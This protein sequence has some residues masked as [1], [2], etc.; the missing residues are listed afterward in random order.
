[1]KSNESR[2]SSQHS[3]QSKPWSTEIHIDQTL[4]L[5]ALKF[6]FPELDIETITS[7]GEG[8]TSSAFLVNEQWVFRFPKRKDVEKN[9]QRE[10]NLL[11][12]FNQ[13]LPVAVPQFSFT[14]PT[15]KSFPFMYAGYRKLEGTF[16]WDIREGG[17]DRTA[18]AHSCA[19][20]L[21]ALHAFPTEEA[22][23]LGCEQVSAPFTTD[24]CRELSAEFDK[25]PAWS[26]RQE[27]EK[28]LHRYLDAVDITELG[29]P[30]ELAVIHSDLLPDHLLLPQSLDGICAIIDWGEVKVGD[31]SVDFAG[32]YYWMGQRFVAEVLSHYRRSYDPAMIE[33]AR[34][35]ALSIGIGDVWYGLDAKLPAYY[36]VGLACLNHCLP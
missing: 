20:I 23:S 36:R 11:P 5:E 4:V 6:D 28:R 13:R 31:P 8:W 34:F 35:F 27:Y 24:S 29:M 33:R 32:L 18:V 22:L 25:I 3:D 7:L 21:M 1:L 12:R 9:L 14:A 19:E 15:P 30:G 2:G 16:A 17:F 26:R 10:L